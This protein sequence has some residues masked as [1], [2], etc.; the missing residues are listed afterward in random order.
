MRQNLPDDSTGERLENR[1]GGGVF[2][3]L[4]MWAGV[5]LLIELKAP[6][7]ALKPMASEK[8]RETLGKGTPIGKADTPERKQSTPERKQSTLESEVIYY[9]SQILRPEQ[10]AF[11]ARVASRRCPGFILARPQRSKEIKLLAPVLK[12][13]TKDLMLMELCTTD[14]W[15]VVFDAMW[16]RVAHL[17]AL[18]L[19]AAPDP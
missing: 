7:N 2:D 9:S 8:V 17:R 11:A 16:R 6:A 18:R 19:P 15:P 14:Q 1:H 4:L 13:R 3:V 12:V 10:R 5:T